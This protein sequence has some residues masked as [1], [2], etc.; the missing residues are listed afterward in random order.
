M[1]VFLEYGVVF[2]V[3]TVHPDSDI[4]TIIQNLLKASASSN[5]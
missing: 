4:S 2:K 1:D 3:L 5:I